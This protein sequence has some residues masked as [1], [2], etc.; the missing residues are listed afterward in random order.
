MQ[1]IHEILW[2]LSWP[3]VIYLGYS[4]CKLNINQLKRVE[5]LDQKE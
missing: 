3:L 1:Y 5:Q 4:F 2:L